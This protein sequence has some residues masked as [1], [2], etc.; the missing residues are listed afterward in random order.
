MEAEFRERLEENA[1][2]ETGIQLQTLMYRAPEILFGK[3]DFDTRV[4][5]WSIG[6]VALEACGVHNHLRSGTG[7]LTQVG[8]MMTMFGM[9]GTPASQDV[10]SW[11]LFPDEPPQFQPAD[12]G[13]AIR[14][15]FGE[16]GADLVRTLVAWSPESRIDAEEASSH[17]ALDPELFPLGGVLVSNARGAQEMEVIPESYIFRGKRHPWSI[18]ASAV[19]PEVLHWLREDSIFE[20][21]EGVFAHLPVDFIAPAPPGGVPKNQLRHK[22]R[23]CTVSGDMGNANTGTMNSMPVKGYLFPSLRVRA[24]RAAFLASNAKA[25]E[26]MVA[27]AKRKVRGLKEDASSENAKHFLKSTVDQ[28]LGSC[29]ELHVSNGSDESRGG[30]LL[31]EEHNDGGA[32]VLHMGLTLWGRR[33]L[34]CRQGEDHDDV[35]VHC[36]PGSVYLGG[37]TGPTHQVQHGAASA[38]EVLSHAHLGSLSISVMFRTSLFPGNRSRLRNTTPSPRALFDTLAGVYN[39]FL[40]HQPLSLPTKA[41]CVQEATRLPATDPIPDPPGKRKKRS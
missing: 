23:K 40:L 20:M 31:E 10:R 6:L 32:S 16:A 22:G 37:L 41:A 13:A 17:D 25:L 29:G 2:L 30:F 3:Q 12:F 14:A 4:D 7:M 8:Y 38:E 27:E 39:D 11:P 15:T 1:L 26:E 35:R 33:T 5:S 36:H 34:T 18:V 21:K 19:A 28:F 24:W 9:F